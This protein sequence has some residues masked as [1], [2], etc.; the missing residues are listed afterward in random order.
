MDVADGEEESVGDVTVE[1]PC[2]ADCWAGG[3][4]VGTEAG[5]KKMLVRCCWID[6]ERGDAHVGDTWLARVF[7]K[8]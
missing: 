7:R 1:K 2:F 8:D 3:L 6:K 4:V 5:E